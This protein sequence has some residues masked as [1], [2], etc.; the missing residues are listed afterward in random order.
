[1]RAVGVDFGSRRIGVAVSDPGGVL[2]SP[3]SVLE[4][5][6]SRAEDHRRLADVVAEVGADV[7]V[8]GLPLSLDG[9]EGP[10][11]RLV[12]DEVAELRARLAVPVEMH[13]ERF[14]TVTADRSLTE[15]RVKGRAKRRVVDKVAAAVLLQSWLDSQERDRD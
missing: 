13:D 1:V 10:A 6:R 8:V 9:S 5:G 4:R 12:Q 7:V 15:R 3:H 2:A 14:T 11:A